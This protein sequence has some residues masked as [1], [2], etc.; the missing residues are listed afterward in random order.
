MFFVLNVEY[1][2]EIADVQGIFCTGLH[3]ITAF[4]R[5]IIPQG[6]SLSNAS[7]DLYVSTLF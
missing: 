6:K 4:W 3:N 7:T 1:M 2:V 5:I